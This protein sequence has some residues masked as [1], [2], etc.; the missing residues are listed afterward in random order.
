M[1]RGEKRVPLGSRTV[2]LMHV[3]R[4]EYAGERGTTLEVTK[5]LN[6]RLVPLLR[7]RARS[8]T[9]ERASLDTSVFEGI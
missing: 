6:Y 2:A 9:G 3:K 5:P 8:A 1:Q 4:E 7:S